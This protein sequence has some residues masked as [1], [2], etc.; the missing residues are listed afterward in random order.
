M[1]AI[2][3]TSLDDLIVRFGAV[4]AAL[5]TIVAALRMFTKFAVR[6]F[7]KAIKAEIGDKVERVYENTMELKPN[8]GS[9]MR[10]AINRLESQQMKLVGDVA[11][12]RQALI[13]HLTEHRSLNPNT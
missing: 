13:D 3:V 7:T 11:A 12:T 2:A 5:V 9:S 4:A 10:D 8:G 1:S 6:Q